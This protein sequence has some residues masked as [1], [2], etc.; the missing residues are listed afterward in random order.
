MTI[1]YTKGVGT[2]ARRKKEREVFYTP[3]NPRLVDWCFISTQKLAPGRVLD[4]SAKL[5]LLVL[6]FLSFHLLMV[7]SSIHHA[8][9]VAILC[10]MTTSSLDVNIASIHFEGAMR[11]AHMY[12]F[13]FRSSGIGPGYTFSDSSDALSC[14]GGGNTT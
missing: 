1:W 3:T 10:Q 6:M 12:V 8:L 4:W 11:H 5:V 9:Q 7:R 13:I 14:W 2:R